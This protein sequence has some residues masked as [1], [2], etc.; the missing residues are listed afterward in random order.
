MNSQTS[1]GSSGQFRVAAIGENKCTLESYNRRDFYKI[2]M[3][4][5]GEGPP[6]H[7]Y[8]GALAPI[9]IDRPALVLI[10]PVVP[11]SWSVP[12]RTTPTEGYFCLFDDDFIR[13]SSQLAG[14]ANRLFAAQESP[15]YF[16]RQ[17]E[18]QFIVE[19]F[20]RMRADADSDY[21][22]KADLF[23]T[24]LGL[25]FQCRRP[26]SNGQIHDQAHQRAGICR[27]KIAVKVYE[28]LRCRNCIRTWF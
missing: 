17:A 21:D 1:R 11:H 12:E 8:Y 28:I 14:L 20:A 22:D 3:V 6:C 7:L 27:S 25:I 9:E 26:E 23:R 2:S 24:H 10:N 4:T 15:V 16:P 13:Q 19:L 5:G 18:L